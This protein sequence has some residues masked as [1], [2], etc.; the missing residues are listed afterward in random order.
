MAIKQNKSSDPG[1]IQEYEDEEPAKRARS[2]VELLH[3]SWSDPL[4]QLL[5]QMSPSIAPTENDED[6]EEES[7]I[8]DASEEES[9]PNQQPAATSQQLATSAVAAASVGSNMWPTHEW[10]QQWRANA[11]PRPS[12]N[13]KVD[14]LSW[15]MEEVRDLNLQIFVSFSC[16]DPSTVAGLHGGGDEQPRWYQWQLHAQSKQVHQATRIERNIQSPA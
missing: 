9:T 1:T 15:V 2:S 6:S 3:D 16:D 5:Y 10:L 11:E 4:M 8:G 13:S 12:L 14:E 7:K